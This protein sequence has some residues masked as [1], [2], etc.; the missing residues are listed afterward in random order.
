MTT[1]TNPEHYALA[2]RDVTKTYGSGNAQ[3]IALRHATLNI[4][5]GHLV[6]ILGPS[7]SG[8]STFLTIA[9]GLQTPTSGKITIDGQDISTLSK[10]ELDQLRLAHIGFVLQAHDLVPYLTVE[11]QFKLVDSVKPKGNL[12]KA[13]LNALLQEL[14]VDQLKHT[15]PSNMSGGQQQRVALARALYTKPSLILADEPTS[16]LDSSAVHTV[17]TLLQN[18]AH[19]QHTTIV[20]VTHDTRLASLADDVYHMQDGVLSYSLDQYHSQEQQ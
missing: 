12:S 17:G 16:A 11:E 18:I 2:M 14:G 8:K 1:P 13:Q 7:G 6:L 20:V 4:P 3:V 9:G 10:H 5:H 19:T 15:L